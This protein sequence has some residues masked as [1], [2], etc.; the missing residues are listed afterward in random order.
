LFNSQ[1]NANISE[2][3][4]STTGF[5]GVVLMAPPAN[6][7]CPKGFGEVGFAPR[8]A[9]DGYAIA[10]QPGNERQ[11]FLSGNLTFGPQKPGVHILCAYTNAPGNFGRSQSQDSGGEGFDLGALSL[12]FETPNFNVTGP[13]NQ[14]LSAPTPPATAAPSN[15]AISDDF[16]REDKNR[17]D[18]KPNIAAIVGGVVGGVAIICILTAVV[19]YRG[20][21]RYQ[22]NNQPTNKQEGTSRPAPLTPYPLLG[23]ISATEPRLRQKEVERRLN[24]SEPDIESRMIFNHEDGGVQLFTSPTSTPLRSVSVLQMPPTYSEIDFR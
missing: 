8:I 21:R 18:D 22:S 14:S 13:A 3:N 6:I 20:L 15:T 4:Q 12:V 23:E 2:F 10:Q 24:N 5:I 17:N 19:F 1:W 7:P 11:D 16:N 9:M